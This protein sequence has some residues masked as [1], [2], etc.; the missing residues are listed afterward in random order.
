[1]RISNVF[2]VHFLNGF[3]NKW[4]PFR[5]D[6]PYLQL[7]VLLI[8]ECILIKEKQFNGIWMLICKYSL[9]PSRQNMQGQCENPV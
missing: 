5:L 6:I 4:K 2:S 3:Y 7:D 8:S 1:M 9:L